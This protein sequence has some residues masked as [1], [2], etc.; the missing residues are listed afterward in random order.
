[1]SPVVVLPDAGLKDKSAL[2]CGSRPGIAG[3]ALADLR[4]LIPLIL[5]ETLFQG[6]AEENTASVAP[7][8]EEIPQ[9]ERQR[10]TIRDKPIRIRDRNQKAPL[11]AM[12]MKGP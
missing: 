11:R 2:P 9:I 12:G 10:I 4:Y 7:G 6:F 1:M 3:E 5:P 8:V